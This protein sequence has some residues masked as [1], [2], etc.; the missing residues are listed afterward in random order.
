MKINF[1]RNESAAISILVQS[2]RRNALRG[3]CYMCT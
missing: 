2:N 3:A 1:V